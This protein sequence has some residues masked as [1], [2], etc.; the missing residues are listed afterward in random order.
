MHLIY[1]QYSP[2]RP[3]FFCEKLFPTISDIFRTKTI[4]AQKRCADGDTAPLR[5]SD[6][7]MSYESILRPIAVKLLEEN[8]NYPLTIVY[9]PLRWCGFAYKLFENILGKAQ[10]YP[11]GSVPDPEAVTCTI[12]CSTNLSDEGND[13]TTINIKI[14][15]STNCFCNSSHWYGG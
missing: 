5:I 7:L 14:F 1:I 4:Y 12:S 3:C 8:V 15:N 11:L 2:K 6:E 9:L 10:Y 13:Y